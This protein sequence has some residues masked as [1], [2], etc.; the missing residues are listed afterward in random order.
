MYMYRPPK[1]GTADLEDLNELIET[2]SSIPSIIIGDLNL[3]D[4]TWQSGKG[5]VKPNSQRVGFHQSALDLVV[6]N[7]FKQLIH[8]PTHI[9][10]NTLDLLLVNKILLDDITIEHV[11]LPR[12]SDHHPILVNISCQGFSKPGLVQKSQ[13]L[14]FKRADNDAI[15]KIFSKLLQHIKDQGKT[16]HH[17]WD[18]FKSAIEQAKSHIPTMLVNPKK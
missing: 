3:P 1:Y 15:E 4:I 16:I 12:I 2:D 6:S 18:L 9:K 13:R 7:D 14:N 8:E 17:I 5:S 11:V 10:S